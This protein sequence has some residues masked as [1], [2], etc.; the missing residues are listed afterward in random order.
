M[1]AR[2]QNDTGDIGGSEGK[3]GGQIPDKETLQVS[4]AVSHLRDPALFFS[5]PF[6][7]CRKMSLWSGQHRSERDVAADRNVRLKCPLYAE[8][9]TG[10]TISVRRRS[11]ALFSAELTFD[12]RV[13]FD[14][15]QCL[16]RK[17]R[18][19]CNVS[20]TSQYRPFRLANTWKKLRKFVRRK[21]N[22]AHGCSFEKTFIS[23]F[24][25]IIGYKSCANKICRAY[26]CYIFS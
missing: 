13:A 12:R 24:I 23:L 5:P 19:S 25:C 8:Y 18:C 6:S 10:K 15:N 16:G 7:L 26:I 2:E 14:M 1:N 22:R 3:K 11:V 21:I 4:A 9:V 20:S 17:S